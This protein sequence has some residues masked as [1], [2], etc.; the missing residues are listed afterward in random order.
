MNTANLQIEGLLLALGQIVTLLKE[1]GVLSDADV[2]AALRRAEAVAM[3]DD[4]R[5]GQ[6]RE[7]N[8][9]AILFPIRYLIE[10]VSTGEARAFRDVTAEVGRAKDRTAGS[11][12]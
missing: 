8:V 11:S 3:G 9:Q 10:T 1:K 7:A 4:G 12:S 6:L 2:A 5:H